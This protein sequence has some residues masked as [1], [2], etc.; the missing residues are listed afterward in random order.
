ML[1]AVGVFQ[2]GWNSNASIG[3]LCAIADAFDKNELDLARGRAMQTLRWLVLHLEVPRDPLV[4]WRLAFLPDPMNIICPV[5]TVD[6]NDTLLNPNQLT[7]T[8]GLARDLELLTKRLG[9]GGAQGSQGDNGRRPPKKQGGGRPPGKA[10][11]P[12]AEE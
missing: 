9:G 3:C 10:Q 8:L 1:L 4:A 2:A 7:A 5:S 12:K 6:L 11:G